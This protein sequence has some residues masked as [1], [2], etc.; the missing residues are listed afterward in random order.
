M[1]KIHTKKSIHR[2]DGD[3][4]RKDIFEKLLTESAI[5]FNIDFLVKNLNIRL[6]G[7]FKEANHDEVTITL[8][9]PV[10]S[11][12]DYLFIMLI[13]MLFLAVLFKVVV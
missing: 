8:E 4:W 2:E 5:T 11:L 10:F 6:S 3:L 13:S 7:I 9:K 12:I 1:I